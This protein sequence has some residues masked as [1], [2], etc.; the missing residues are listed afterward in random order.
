MTRKYTILLR[1]LNQEGVMLHV[2]G[3]F[4]RRGY[5]ID[6]IAVGTCEKPEQSMITIVVSETERKEMVRQIVSQ[7]SKLASVID[8][9]AFPYNELV[10]REL[11]LILVK[12]NNKDEQL[13]ALGIANAFGAS[14]EDMTEDTIL[15]DI[16]SL[17]RKVRALVSALA[18]KFEILDIARTG[19][20]ALPLSEYITII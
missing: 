18:V 19:E 4:A 14:I 12:Y 1:V 3:L 5:N 9:R 2:V 10:N 6:S 17:S 7:L 15:I 11:A 8:V 13:E 20:I 16:A